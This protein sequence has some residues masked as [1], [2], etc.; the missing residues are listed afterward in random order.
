MGDFTGMETP[1][2]IPVSVLW[3]CS[4]PL[5]F[6]QIFEDTNCFSLENGH[7]DHNLSGRYALD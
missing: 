1:I 2:S 3:T 7:F 6:N 4:S 5:R